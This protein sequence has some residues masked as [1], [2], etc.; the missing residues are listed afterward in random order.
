MKFRVG[1]M[2]LATLIITGILLVMFG[3]LPNLIPGRYYL[4][5]VQFDYAGSVTKG[6][7]VRKS[8]ILIGRVENVRLIDQD[9]KVMVTAKIDGDKKIYQNE[10]CCI[11]R[12]LLGDSSLVF[13][14]SPG[15]PGSGEPIKPGAILVG[16]VTDDPTGLKKALEGPINTVN[17][18]GLALKEASDQLKAAA[19]KV[20][21][22]LD[23]ERGRISEVLENAAESLKAVRIVLGDQETQQRLAEAMQKLPNTLDSMNNTFRSADESL[24]ALTQRSGPDGRTPIERMVDTIEMTERTLRKFSQPAGP[25]EEAPVDQIAIAMEN[26]GE[27]TTLMRTIMS[28]IERGEGSLGSLL[29]D[30]QLYNSLCRAAKNIERVSRELQPIVADA[31]VFTDKIARHPGVIVRDAVKQGTG[32]K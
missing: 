3:K 12:D 8:G 26:I 15:K 2:F 25:G 28:R 31:R 32:L 1:V 30:R 23:E 5:E 10:N 7:P 16:E 24:R 9:S 19:K 14:P 21:D 13:V 11:T 17:Q 22:I 4:V 18:T 6:T 29:N 20:E 27:I